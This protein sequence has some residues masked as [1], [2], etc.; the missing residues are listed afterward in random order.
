MVVDELGPQR[1]RLVE[2]PFLGGDLRQVQSGDGR[3]V[4]AAVVRPHGREQILGTGPAGHRIGEGRRLRIVRL[5]RR[6]V[7]RRLVDLHCMAQRFSRLL[8]PV[9]EVDPADQN[10]NGHQCH[11]AETQKQ[12]ACMALGILDALPHGT[13]EVVPLHVFARQML[14]HRKS[15][16]KN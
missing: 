15:S 4:A 9:A 3:R 8:G 10:Q 7:D 2:L 14:R 16:E 6:G 13:G 5:G 11:R 1:P 12:R